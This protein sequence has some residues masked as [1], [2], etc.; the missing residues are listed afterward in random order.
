MSAPTST[1]ETNE[2]PVAP[3]VIEEENKIEKAEVTV[4]PS[5]EEPQKE[6]KKESSQWEGFDKRFRRPEDELFDLAS[7]KPLREEQIE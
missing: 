4:Q 5:T 6:E 3:K 1:P 2:K 7:I